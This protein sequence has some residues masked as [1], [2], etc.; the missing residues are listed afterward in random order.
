MSVV[1]FDANI[2]CVFYP[3][4]AWKLHF[5]GRGKG[6]FEREAVPMKEVDMQQ[7]Y[8]TIRKEVGGIAKMVM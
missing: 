8:Y 5:N 4:I 1:G 7:Y 6:A 3:R 2:R